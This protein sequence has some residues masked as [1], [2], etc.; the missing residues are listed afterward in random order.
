MSEHR[1]SSVQEEKDEQETTTN[2]QPGG[3]TALE[4][5]EDDREAGSDGE[6]VEANR[7]DPGECR[8]STGAALNTVR[9]MFDPRIH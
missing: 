7:S 4:A 3:T 5:A 9:S 2:P 8:W 6:E 1:E